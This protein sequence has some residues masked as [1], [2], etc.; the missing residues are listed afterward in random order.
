[1]GPLP[2]ITDP[3]FLN[4]EPEVATGERMCEENEQEEGREE[5]EEVTPESSKREVPQTK[6]FPYRGAAKKKMEDPVDFMEI[7]DKLE[8]NLPFLHALKLPPFS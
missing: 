1:M 5:K 3:F 8:I 4:Q 7:F 2:Q 6:P